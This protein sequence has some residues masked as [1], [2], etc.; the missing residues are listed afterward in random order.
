ME[1]DTRGRY[2]HFGLTFVFGYRSQRSTFSYF[3][4]NNNIIIM[5]FLVAFCGRWSID[6]YVFCKF[7]ERRWKLVDMWR[8]R[9]INEPK[10][11]SNVSDPE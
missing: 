8:V 9:Y 4:N 10:L 5:I 3:R 1:V 2:C 11:Y 7:T 6:S